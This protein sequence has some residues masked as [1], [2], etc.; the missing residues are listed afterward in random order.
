MTAFE[1]LRI[2]NS[3]GKFIAVGLDADI[4]KIPQHLKSSANPVLEFNKSI[5]EATKKFAGAYKINF[6]FYEA[7][8]KSGIENI[9]STL[10][11]IPSDVLTIADGKRGDIGNTSEMYAKAIYDRLHFDSATLNPYMGEDSL[12]PF[13]NYKD[14]LNFILALTSNPGSGDFQKSE[15]KEGGFLYQSVIQKVTR[16]NTSKNCGIVFGATNP[17]ELKININSFGDLPVLIPGIGAQGGDLEK[18]TRILG[19]SKNINFLVNVSR[20]ILYKNNTSEFATA[21]REEIVRLNNLIKS[22]L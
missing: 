18:I 4:N 8:G 10:S 5:I 2:Q 1:K 14:K 19:R 7:E 12:K 17:D 20:G 13:L 22:Y 9:E 6:A 16:W 21:A 11:F 3:N 15:M